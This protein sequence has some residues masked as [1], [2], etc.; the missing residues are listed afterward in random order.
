M[1]SICSPKTVA[2]FQ[3]HPKNRT[4]FIQCSI[5]LL[6]FMSFPETLLGFSASGLQGLGLQGLHC[7]VSWRSNQAIYFH[8]LWCGLFS[9]VIRIWRKVGLFSPILQALMALWIPITPWL[10]HLFSAAITQG[11]NTRICGSGLSCRTEECKPSGDWTSL[12]K[13]WGS[14]EPLWGL[15]EVCA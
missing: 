15:Q 5:T 7:R 2:P 9:L 10:T 8:V 13:I 12:P 14:I 11:T 4:L 6:Y 1:R 3:F